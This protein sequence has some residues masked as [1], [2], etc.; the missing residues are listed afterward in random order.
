MSVICP[1]CQKPVEGAILKV[2]A[3]AERDRKVAA[4]QAAATQESA[5]VREEMARYKTAAE[6]VA[7]DLV[8]E[9]EKATGAERAVRIA[10]VEAAG[11]SPVYL[12]VLEM[13]YAELP[14]KD[15]PDFKTAL[16]PNGA[17][18]TAPL[19]A[20]YF[21]TQ[22]QAVAA[23]PAQSA[24]QAA[25]VQSA[26][27]PTPPAAATASVPDLSNAIAEALAKYGIKPAQQGSPTAQVQIVAGTPPAESAK[28]S[29]AQ[30]S[31]HLA[32]KRRTMKPDEYKTYLG[33]L[34]SQYVSNSAET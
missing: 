3:D 2:E 14:E 6:Q 1:S 17:L 19:T 8:K 30:L 22:P 26:A 25:P 29:P 20:P 28:M 16:G 21:A 27:A 10:Q 5:R 4:A 18:R 33:Q 9:R 13:A 7:A 12:P 23:Q 34:E 31:A 32:E 11:L 15:R 24:A